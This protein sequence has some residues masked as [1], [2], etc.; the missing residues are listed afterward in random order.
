MGTFWV[1]LFVCYVLFSFC[2]FYRALLSIVSVT[3]CWPSL[4]AGVSSMVPSTMMWDNG[5]SA[6][7]GLLSLGVSLLSSAVVVVVVVLVVV[8][9]V[10]VVVAVVVLSVVEGSSGVSSEDSVSGLGSSVVV[11]V[12]TA[13]VSQKPRS[14]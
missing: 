1:W 12:A 6:S 5:S 9:V 13:G 14:L 3:C 10:V 7:R 11:A 2:F 4:G 8:Q